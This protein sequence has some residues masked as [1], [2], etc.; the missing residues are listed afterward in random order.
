MGLFKPDLY[1]SLALG[2]VL[3]AMAIV[4]AQG[5]R[6]GQ[7]LSGQMIPAANAAPELSDQTLAAPL[8]DRTR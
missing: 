4:A 3:G 1:R 6:S 8:I 2:F 7:T 5:F